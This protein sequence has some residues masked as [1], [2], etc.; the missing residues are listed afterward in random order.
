MASK[1]PATRTP[2][3]TAEISTSFGAFGL[4]RLRSMAQRRAAI[5]TP[6]RSATAFF[7]ART[8]SSGCA[9]K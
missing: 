4:P 3:G 9:L 5:G 6:T 7:T 8:S 2:G 1:L